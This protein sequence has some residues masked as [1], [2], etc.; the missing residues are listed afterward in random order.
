MGSVYTVLGFEWH[1]AKAAANLAKHGVSF[2]D[3]ATAFGDGNGL[4]A[5][6]VAHSGEEPRRLRMG[7]SSSGRLIVVAYTTRRRFDEEVVRN[8]SARF[9]SRRERRRYATPEH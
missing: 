2:E 7:L 4:D 6:D 1:P 3:A 8:I 5:P 9:A